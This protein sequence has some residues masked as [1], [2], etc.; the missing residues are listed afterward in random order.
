MTK[1][2]LK[3]PASSSTLQTIGAGCPNSI[4]AG[5]PN[6]AADVCTPTDSTVTGCPG[7]NA[8][9]I[10]TT[11]PFVPL[12]DASVPLLDA[13]EGDTVRKSKKWPLNQRC[14]EY[15]QY[16]SNFPKLVA[17][18]KAKLKAKIEDIFGYNDLKDIKIGEVNLSRCSGTP[19]L[20]S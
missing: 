17:S 3:K 15:L 13:A 11:S 5:C 9:T 7:D 10:G 12:L 6:T 16:S 18:D 19:I 1:K 4:G 2:L 8:T 14:F 20:D